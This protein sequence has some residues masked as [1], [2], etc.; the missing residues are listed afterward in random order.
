MCT[1]VS[2]TSW[3]P[4]FATK[5]NPWFLETIN[6][7]LKQRSGIGIRR[8]SQAIEITNASQGQLLP[9]PF[10]VKC[11]QNC[12]NKNAFYVQRLMSFFP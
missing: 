9:S 3:F 5:E 1:G 4:I 11:E 12:S 6:W 10:K 8:Q 7:N 2:N